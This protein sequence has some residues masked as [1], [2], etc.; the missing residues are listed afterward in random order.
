MV[1]IKICGIT[2]TEDALKIACLGADALGFVLSTDSPRKIKASKAKEIIITVKEK[3]MDLPGYKLPSFAGIF[4]NET[5]E[6]VTKA[7]DKLELDFMQFCGNEDAEYML[8]VKKKFKNIKLIKMIRI[9]EYILSIKSLIPQLQE[10]KNTVD[11][12]LLDTYK[13][14]FYGGMGISFNWELV[15]GLS[16]EFSVILAGGLDS[17]NV[18]E[19]IKTVKPFGIDA[20]T[21]LEESPGK[22]DITKVEIFIKNALKNAD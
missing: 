11:Y 4:V 14:N 20:S 1:W 22:K 8:K 15:K 19:A 3:F 16:R 10:Y 13:E 21:R 18:S 9:K 17:K 2:N 6:A 7:A 5:I 12:F